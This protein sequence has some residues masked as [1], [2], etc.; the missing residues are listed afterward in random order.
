MTRHLD[1]RSGQPVWTM[2]GMPRIP[3]PPLEGDGAADAVIVGGG[4]SG[5][6]VADSLLQAGLSVIAIDR[7]EFGRGSSAASTAL[8]AT[9]LD[10]PLTQLADEVGGEKAARAYWRSAA[11]V[12]FLRAR[13]RDLRLQARFRDRPSVYLPGNVLGLTALRRE[14]EA[15]ARIGLRS[16]FIEGEAL[17][18]LTALQVAGATVTAGSAEADPL[19]LVGGLWRSAIARGASLHAPVEAREVK[20]SRAGVTIT[21]ADGAR[22]KARHAVFATGY[23]LL[24]F[25]PAAASDIRSTW[26][27]ATAPQT[28]WPN[29][30]LV[31]EA[32]DPYFYT[33]T[34][35][36]GRVVAGGEDEPFA[37]D[38]KRDALIA[39]KSKAIARKIAALWPS[40]DPT[41]EFRWTGSFGESRTGLPTIGR[42]PGMDR[43]FAVLGYGG[44]GFTFSAIAAQIISRAILGL[45]DPDEAVF[46]FDP[47]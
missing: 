42:I 36:D 19:C 5:A 32:S 13:I 9:E 44:N 46:G 27:I 7:R 10:R 38:D 21:T 29:R 12:G 2:N 28:V 24:P 25:V 20:E 6:L 41:P 4:V 30:A 15:R 31:W 8:L 11:A 23:E 45:P 35:P 3:A 14:C 34:T 47:K 17:H 37:D 16:R 18:R 33:R 22:I 39:K 1:L 43:C 26:A 40:L